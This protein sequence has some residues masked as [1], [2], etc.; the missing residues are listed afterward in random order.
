MAADHQEENGIVT[1]SME[2]FL[3]DGMPRLVGK[4]ALTGSAFGLASGLLESGQTLGGAAIAVAGTFPA[5]KLVD[6]VYFATK[7]EGPSQP[8]EQ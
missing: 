3:G 8:T 6:R 7:G 2:W 1:R 4:L 5:W